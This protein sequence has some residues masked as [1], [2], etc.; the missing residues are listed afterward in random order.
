MTWISWAGSFDT[1]EHPELGQF[2]LL[3]RR[4]EWGRA[5]EVAKVRNGRLHILCGLFGWDLPMC[6]VFLSRREITEWKRPGPRFP[7]ARR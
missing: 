3:F 4:Q 7:S 2:E 6:C 5:L 1:P